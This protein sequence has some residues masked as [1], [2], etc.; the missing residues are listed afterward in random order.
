ML[1]LGSLGLHIL[2]LKMPWPSFEPD[3]F[4]G[5]VSSNVDEQTTMN[6]AILP[7]Q[8]LEAAASAELEAAPNLELPTKTQRAAAAPIADPPPDGEAARSPQAAPP[9]RPEEPPP[10]RDQPTTPEQP[11]SASSIAENQDSPPIDDLPE[12]SGLGGVSVPPQAPPTPP[13][14]LQD[15]TAYQ[16]DGRKS[17]GQ[18]EVAMISLGWVAEGQTLPSKVDPIELPYQLGEQCL[19]VPPAMGL[20]MAVLNVDGS[21]QRGPEIVSST[22]YAVLDQQ[23]KALVESGEYGFP[24]RDEARAYSIEVKVLYPSNCP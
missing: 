1:I 8:S 22:G 19:D 10:P 24:K 15:A 7:P 23:A 17:L 13:N 11:P 5:M 3:S 18:A 2:A 21:F 16:Y 14:P 6:V 12:E 20:M 4:P 9:P